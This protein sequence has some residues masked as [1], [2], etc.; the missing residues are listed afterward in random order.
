MIPDKETIC[1]VV[2]LYK[3]WCGEWTEQS[4]SD[5]VQEHWEERTDTAEMASNADKVIRGGT[6]YNVK[7][8]LPEEI[9]RL[10]PDY[11]IYPHI[12]SDYAYGFLTRGCPNLDK[13]RG[14]YYCGYGTPINK[15]ATC[16]RLMRK[17]KGV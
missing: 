11:S 9:D 14:R 5:Y 12:P 17:R 10:Q 8:R 15:V 1:Q 7:S 13:I 3:Q 2:E 16:L 6:G 4:L